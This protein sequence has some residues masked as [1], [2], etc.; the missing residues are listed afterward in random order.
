MEET[1]ARL[2][3]GRLIY[4]GSM[5][6]TLS[7][8]PAF[9]GL[10]A[11]AVLLVVLG[12]SQVPEFRGGGL[13]VD[14]FFVLSGFLITTLLLNE[15]QETGRLNYLNFYARRACRLYPA[16][17]LFLLIYALIAHAYR[18]DIYKDILITGL[19]FT[20]YAIAFGYR[21]P[22][23][24]H[25]WSLAVEEH[26]YIVFPPILIWLSR[27]CSKQTIIGLLAGAYVF[28]TS[29]KIAAMHLYGSEQLFQVYFRFD[30]RLSGVLLGSLLATAL[31]SGYKVPAAGTGMIVSAILLLA[32]IYWTPSM[33][34]LLY[35]TT[36][37]EIF[38][39]FAITKIMEDETWLFARWLADPALV[40]LGRISYAIYLFHYPIAT[41]LA[42]RGLRGLT[43]FE[44]TF[45]ISAL[46][47]WYAYVTVEQVG[48]RFA[49]RFRKHQHN[50]GFP[51]RLPLRESF[52]FLNGQHYSQVGKYVLKFFTGILIA[53]CIQTVMVSAQQLH[54]FAGTLKP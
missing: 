50:P 11:I 1:I 33:P 7:Y 4:S 10:R 28:A 48:R 54:H 22:F 16:L 32:C 24:Q 39:V 34:A 17:L 20:D 2:H 25:T 6:K 46:L 19:Y 42:F 14:I 21:N 37:A 41:F 26:F 51:S 5:G 44:A 47:A 29:W 53:A 40:A 27:H 9:D 35:E 15:F 3:P 43:A 12:H 36:A 49:Q 18:P 13:G 31:S 30:T 8:V 45:A 23:T 38:T 52:V